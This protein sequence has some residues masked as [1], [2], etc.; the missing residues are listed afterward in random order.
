MLQATD[1]RTDL[2]PRTAR[3]CGREALGGVRPHEPRLVLAT[4][5]PYGRGHLSTRVG[6]GVG[7]GVGLLRVGLRARV[8]L[9]VRG[10][11][12]HPSPRG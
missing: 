11:V 4:R 1:V 9:R 8:R 7:V 6:L 10:H 12:A 2:T 3:L 5:V